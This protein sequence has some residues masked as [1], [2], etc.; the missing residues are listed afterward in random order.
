MPGYRRW[1]LSRAGR[2]VA[3]LAALGLPQL[4]HLGHSLLELDVLALFVA[5]SLVL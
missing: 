5:M 1:P 2:L 3:P 4:V